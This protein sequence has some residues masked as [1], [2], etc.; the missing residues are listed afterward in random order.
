MAWTTYGLDRIAQRLVLE[1]K[2]QDKDSLNQAYKMRMAVA[3]GLERFW[4]EQLRLREKQQAKAN[5]WQ[6]TW[7][8]LVEVMANAGVQLPNDAV[9]PKNTAQVKAMAAKL[10]DVGLDDQRVA[11]AVLTQL[12][13]CLVWWTQ[14]HK[15]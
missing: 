10:W 15:G 11:I 14:R 13:D 3:Y 6:A 4:G 9:D 12:C 2:Q 5:Y 1:A 7:N 8:A